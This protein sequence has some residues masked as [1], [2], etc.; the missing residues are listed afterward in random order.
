MPGDDGSHRT[1]ITEALRAL[2]IKRLVLALHDPSFPSEAEEE[3]GRGSPCTAGGQRFLRFAAALGFNAVQLGPQGELSPDNPSPYDGALFARST[4]SIALAP[5]T[6][7]GRWGRL[8]SP[9]TLAALVEAQAEVAGGGGRA[10]R[11]LRAHHRSAWVAQQRALAEAWETFQRERVSTSPDPS[12]LDLAARLSAFRRRHA[13]WLTREVLYDPLCTLH[14]DGHFLR[15]P[16]TLDQRLFAPARGEEVAC[17][18]R[19]R[20]LSAEH[21]GHAEAVAF[22]QLLAHEQHGALREVAAG[23]GLRLY[24]DLQVGMPPRD[25]WAYR[26]LLL[27]DYRMGAPPSRTNPEGQP[28]GYPLLDPDQLRGAAG[29]FFRARIDKSLDE[30]DGLRV[31]HPHGL[32][33]PWVYLDEAPDPGESVRRGARLFSSPAL[34]DH[35]TLSRFAIAAPFQLDRGLPRHA[36]AWVTSL[37]PTQVEQYAVLVDGLVSAA[38]ARG[39]EKADLAF[40]VLSTLPLPVRAALERHGLGRFRVTQKANLADPMDVYRSERAMPADWV[41]VGTHD[42]PSLWSVL[43]RWRA[44]KSV[45]AQAAYL[46]ERVAPREDQVASLARALSRDQALLAR[47]KFADLFAS[48]AAHV[49]VFFADL[50]GMKEPYN[51]PGTVSD[52]NWSLR[53]PRDYQQKYALQAT[54]GAALDLPRVLAM[55]LRARGAGASEERAALADKLMA[56]PAAPPPVA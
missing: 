9:E 15:W 47:A 24:G 17:L 10:K 48:G 11:F 6:E 30:Y 41:M 36:D 49:S 50:L 7:P 40:E 38:R 53:V 29:G 13:G 31:D 34:P 46:A 45:E 1:L 25:H 33:D 51:Q 42:T 52:E 20:E 27:R 16:Q 2:N 32:V 5:L 14:G 8:L 26:A 43:D 39:W 19:V 23:I 12:V 44:E 21:A 35:P 18:A 4:L 3:L 56:L 54:R 28:W 37:S 22:Q 55:A